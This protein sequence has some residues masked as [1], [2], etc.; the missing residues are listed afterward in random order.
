[1]LFRIFLS[2]VFT[3]P[4]L[5][6]EARSAGPETGCPTRTFLSIPPPDPLSEVWNGRPRYRLVIGAGKFPTDPNSD[7]TFVARTALYVDKALAEAGYSETLGLL[8]DDTATKDN[9]RSAFASIATVPETALILIYY[10]GHGIP[11]PDGK[12]LALATADDK[13]DVGNGVRVLDLLALPLSRID[14]RMRQMPRITLVIESCYSGQAGPFQSGLSSIIESKPTD[15][16]RLA[17][18]AA[19]TGPNQQAW[20]LLQDGIEYGAF[21]YFLAR[22]LTDEWTCADALPDGALT[23]LE[24]SAYLDERLTTARSDGRIKGAMSPDQIDRGGYSMIAYN[25]SRIADA[26]GHRKK[27]RGIYAVDI[28]APQYGITVATAD[29]ETV[30]NCINRCRFVTDS[31]DEL[32]VTV[33]PLLASVDPVPI[34]F[35]KMRLGKDGIYRLGIRT[36][37]EA[38]LHGPPERALIRVR[39][40]EG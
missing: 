20:P 9:I 32:V 19:T 25:P 21:G 28:E 40:S 13:V 30:T 1:M 39:S 11:A 35:Y 10:I 15:F 37:A 2:V 14:P 6:T 38:T 4:L 5:P 33:S 29:G 27:I 12:D 8:V 34:S 23:V 22:G 3:I 36:H 24:L 7:R 31:P 18:L 17:F 16:R 26:D